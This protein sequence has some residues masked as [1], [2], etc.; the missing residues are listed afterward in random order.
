MHPIDEV[1]AYKVAAYKVAAY[2]VSNIVHLL[3]K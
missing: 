3:N 1:A 2:E